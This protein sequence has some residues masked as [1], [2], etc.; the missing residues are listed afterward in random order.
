M[1]C[2][3]HLCWL[4]IL[5]A[6]INVVMTVVAAVPTI[7]YGPRSRT[8]ILWQPAAFGVIAN[9]TPPLTYQ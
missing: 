7:E 5:A 3:S 1:R 9:G 2:K 8:V 6:L 4:C